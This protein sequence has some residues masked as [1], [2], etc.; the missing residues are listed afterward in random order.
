MINNQIGKQIKHLKTNNK[1]ELYEEEING[2]HMNDAIKRHGIV[3]LFHCKM[4]LENK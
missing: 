3:R 4:L 1:M 2:F